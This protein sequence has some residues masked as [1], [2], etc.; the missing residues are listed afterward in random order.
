MLFLTLAL[1][2]A[3]AVMRVVHLGGFT[4]RLAR[5]ISIPELGAITLAEAQ[6]NLQD[7][8]AFAVIDE[9]RR[10]SWLLDQ[11]VFDD[12]VNPSGGG[13]TLTYGYT[14]LVTAASAAFRAFNTEYTPGKATRQRYTVDLKP[15]GGSF[16]IDRVLAR[17]GAAATNEES[18]QFDQ[19]TKTVRDHFQWAIINGDIERAGGDNAEGFD[20]LSKALRSSSTEINAD[21]TLDWTAGTI[22]TEA[23]A[24]TA[25][26]SLDQLV[27]KVDGGANAILGNEQSLARVRSIARRAGYYSRTEDALGRVVE[28]YGSQV[29]V[30]LGYVGDGGQVI[31]TGN[32]DVDS[33][34]YTIAVTGSPTGGTFK[35]TL[36]VDGGGDVESGTIAF[37][38]TAATIQTALRAMSNVGS[39]NV[40]VTG[41]T[42]KTIT[43]V[44]ALV[45]APVVLT[46]TS[47]ALSGGSTPSVTVTEVAVT[48]DGSGLTDLYAVRF[49]LDAFHAVSTVGA[50]V[51]VYRPDY[52]APG[53]IKKGEVEMGPLAVVL[54][55]TRGAS[56]LR[57]IKV[58]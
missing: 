38:A 42:T 41:T 26:D 20:G 49:G 54:K 6:V 16:E 7:D 12:C 19:L 35:I 11:M 40:T 37:D 48:A 53:V 22:A 43:F 8:V 25:L 29:L 33:S 45:D 55:A 36:N 58:Q 1:L 50:L 13:S 2:T 51:S 24:H 30:D 10:K 15:L 44:R 46:M 39:P 14:R 47:N 9:T 17:L 23:L 31:G 57:N 52:T 5:I 21:A 3:L 28:K 34:T 27:N 18:F 56:V 32:R 4:A